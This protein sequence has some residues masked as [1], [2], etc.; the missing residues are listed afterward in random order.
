MCFIMSLVQIFNFSLAYMQF[1]A[2]GVWLFGTGVYFFRTLGSQGVAG[3]GLFG[4]GG[5]AHYVSVAY[6]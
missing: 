4:C 2:K 6:L 1:P 3:G 5:A